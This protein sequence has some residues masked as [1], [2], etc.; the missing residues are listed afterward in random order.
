MEHIFVINLD[1]ATDRWSHYKD[2]ERY[3][4]WSATTI[5][6][7]PLNHEI[8][9]KMI[10]YH[11]IS[12]YEH[13]AKCACYLSHTKLWKHIVENKL[14]NVIILEDDA[15]LVNDIPDPKDLPKD[16]FTYLGGFTSHVKLT[17]GHKKVEFKE[18]I[19][20]IDNNE[21][22]MLMCLAIYIPTWDTA[23]KM[24]QSSTRNG[25]CRAIDTM[26]RDTFRSQYVYYPACF[27][28]RPVESQ[29][30][31]N[32]KKFSNSNYEWVNAKTVMQEINH[33][34]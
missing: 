13:S 3:T 5:D 24:I 28:E 23:Y 1:S 20:Q 29:I 25:R 31:N 8:W 33:L 17:D 27:I 11:N 30:R 2:D 18:G 9:N 34:L 32:K 16:G 26:I 12:P 15:F 14:N 10:S 21:Y 19:N 4:R 6:D 7:I 22:R